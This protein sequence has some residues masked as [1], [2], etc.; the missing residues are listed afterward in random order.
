LISYDLIPFKKVNYKMDIESQD[1][2]VRIPL[3]TKCFDFWF[4]T[5]PLCFLCLWLIMMLT[6]AITISE[7]A[8]NK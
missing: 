5:N 3:K 4:E 2:P 1:K 8:K 7:L 6:M